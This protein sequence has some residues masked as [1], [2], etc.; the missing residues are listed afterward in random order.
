MWPLGEGPAGGKA[1]DM[2]SMGTWVSFGRDATA[3]ELEGPSKSAGEPPTFSFPSS[4]PFYYRQ[5]PVISGVITPRR[6]ACR[7]PWK[8]FVV[9]FEREIFAAHTGPE[10]RRKLRRTRET[11]DTS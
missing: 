8:Y 5:I 7:K 9:R 1:S 4:I 3:T 6:F 10:R 2:W 11:E